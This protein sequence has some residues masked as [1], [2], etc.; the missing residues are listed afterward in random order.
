M[1][2]K[3]FKLEIV[4]KEICILSLNSQDKNINT[5]NKIA[6]DEL[7]EI[8][9]LIKKDDSIKGVIIN[10]LKKDFHYGYNLEQLLKIQNKREFIKSN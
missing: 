8:I 9:N 10:S 6:V 2:F 7:C 4:D 3:N 1:E 5:V